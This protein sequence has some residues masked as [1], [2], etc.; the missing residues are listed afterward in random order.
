[1]LRNIIVLISL[2]MTLVVGVDQARV[3]LVIYD[4]IDRCWLSMAFDAET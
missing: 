2:R 1:M 4:R 3:I